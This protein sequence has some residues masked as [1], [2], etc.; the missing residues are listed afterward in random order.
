MRTSAAPTVEA[1][2]Y[3]S[4]DDGALIT[5]VDGTIASGGLGFA[6]AWAGDLDADGL[7]DWVAG[8]P[9][10][11]ELEWFQGW[12]FVAGQVLVHR[13]LFPSQVLAEPGTRALGSY[14]AARADLDGDG[15]GDLAIASSLQDQGTTPAA[16]PFDCDADGSPD[17]TGQ[18]CGALYFYSGAQLQLYRTEIGIE[19]FGSFGSGF[20]C[21]NSCTQLGGFCSRTEFGA[22]LAFV[23]DSTGDGIEDYAYRT[24]V[25]GQDNGGAW[26]SFV[27]IAS[28][29]DGT[30]IWRNRE[31]DNYAITAPYGLALSPAADLDGD[32]RRDV[33]VARPHAKLQASPVRQPG[34][35]GFLATGTGLEHP[36][37][38]G[39][40]DW[41][42][43]GYSIAFGGDLNGDGSDDYILGSPAEPRGSF[44]GGPNHTGWNRVAI[45]FGEARTRRAAA[46]SGFRTR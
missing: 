32:G 14:L 2:T 4:G 22:S 15:V 26:A 11:H 45:L 9:G 16:M 35:V 25:W 8:A 17:I 21:P 44:F 33:L 38:G 41:D 24:T 31:I 36:L 28:G 37:A 6:V 1:C 7:D 34:A 19:P 23:G 3:F 29:A 12:P 18:S 46:P 27:T 42:Y 13:S 39:V 5:R 10:R 43:Y 20:D 30:P 40:S